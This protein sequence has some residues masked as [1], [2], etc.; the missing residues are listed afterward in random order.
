MWNL[1]NNINVLIYKTEINPQRKKIMFTKEEAG[2]GKL[3]VWVNRY[4]LLYVK[5]II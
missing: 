3:G 1:K 4:I 5:Y 2:R